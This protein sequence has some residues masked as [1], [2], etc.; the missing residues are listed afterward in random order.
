MA[1]PLR[2]DRF[3]AETLEQMIFGLMTGRLRR[4]SFPGLED[5]VN[6]EFS[7]EQ[8][9]NVEMRRADVA[10]ERVRRRLGF[11]ADRRHEED[12]DLDEIQTA[13]EN[14]CHYL[15]CRMFHYGEMLGSLRQE[16]AGE[17]LRV[18]FWHTEDGRRYAQ[19]LIDSRRELDEQIRQR[20][21]ACTPD[22]G[23]FS[24][25]TARTAER[26]GTQIPDELMIEP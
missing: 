6:D 7:G 16:T 3:Y 25:Y 22:Q 23:A 21:A 5:L 8:Y 14:V 12:D 17:Y 10:L 4:S 19:A 13:W 24:A 18:P 15:C 11:Q 1:R 2:K 26:N 20:V 9:C